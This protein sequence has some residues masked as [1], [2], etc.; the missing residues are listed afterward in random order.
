MDDCSSSRSNNNNNVVAGDS[1]PMLIGGIIEKGF[2]TASKSTSTP[3][4]RPTVLPFP[5]PRHRSHGPHWSSV[6]P[7]IEDKD[8]DEDEDETN[9]D[10]VA[11]SANP[12]QRKKKKGL[13]FGN[14]REIIPSDR[15]ATNQRNQMKERE[16]SAKE[17]ID[18]GKKDYKGINVSAT[19]L[20]NVDSFPNEK[21]NGEFDKMLNM[22]IN[23]IQGSILGRPAV[24]IS[25][26]VARESKSDHSP[27]QSCNDDEIVSQSY[28][29]NMFEGSDGV[30]LSPSLANDIDAE[31][32]ARLE[33][34]SSDEIAE[35]QAEIVGKM[36]PNILE[37]LKKRGR[38]KLANVRS[39]KSG[40]EKGNQNDV[41]HDRGNLQRGLKG[42]QPREGAEGSHKM[43]PTSEHTHSNAS[44][45]HLLPSS[46]QGS[47]FWK[48][49]AERVEAVR[50]L[51]FTLDGHV[52]ETGLTQPS[53]SGDAPCS[54][55]SDKNVAERDFL[56]TEG[57]PGGAGYTIKEAVALIRS[58]IPGQRVLALRLLAS[59]L[60]KALCNLELK[61]A[62]IHMNGTDDAIKS[63]DWQ[64]IW[65]YALGPEPEI[66]LSLRMA[67]DDNHN[68]VILSCAKVIHSI[69]SCEMNE[70]FFNT[71]EKLANYEMGLYTAPI[72]R[73]RPDIKDGFLNG[74]FWKYN[75]KPSNVLPFIEE[76][77]ND[78]A[79]G[80]HT[81]QDDIVVAGQDIA[82]GLVRMGI[83]PRIR[84][85]LE[86]EPV[87]V[88]DE[89]LISI[90]IALGRH[91][92]E[93]AGAI[94]KCT[95]LVQT[96]MQ[97]YTKRDDEA[98]H[99]SMIKSARLIRVLAQCN[100]RYCID[101]IERGFFWVIMSHLCKYAFSP[102]LD[103]WIKSGKENC[104]L[105][106][107]FIVEQLSLWKVCIQYGYCVSHFADLFPVL[108]V[109]LS[110]PSFD[111]LIKSN[112]LGEFT[113]ISR[114]AYFVLAA[115]AKQLPELHS[116]EQ[117]NN[118]KKISDNN[119][120]AWSWSHVSPMVDVAIKW[121]S[122]KSNPYLSSMFDVREE[123]ANFTQDSSVGS[124]VCIISAVVHMLSCVLDRIVPCDANGQ[125]GNKK[126]LPW[127]PDFVPKIGLTI[128]NSGLL[129]LSDT[130]GG[131]SLVECLSRLRCYNNLELSL[132]FISCLQCLV[133]LAV[134]VD[135]CIQSAKSDNCTDSQGCSFE[136]D[137]VILR[138]GIV[139]WCLNDLKILLT[140]FMKFIASGW[141][142]FRSIEIYGRGGP[143]PGSGVGWGASA[144]GFWS[145]T[146]LLIQADA[147]LVLCLQEHFPIGLDTL[148]SSLQDREPATGHSIS[149]TSFTLQ[150]INSIL[151]VCLIGGPREKIT[152]EKA[153]DILLQVPTLKYFTF[154]IQRLFRLNMKSI[155][156]DYMLISR[157]LNTHFRNR[158]LNSKK[159]SAKKNNKEI[160]D[161]EQK[162]NALDT[163]H[164][165]AEM[166]ETTSQHPQC[167]SLVVE[168]AYQRLPLPLHWFLSPISTFGDS[169]TAQ[170]VMNESNSLAKCGIFLLLGLEA[171][172]SISSDSEHSPV[173]NVPLV[174][175]LHA[176]SMVLLV[177]TEILEDETYRA[178]YE[179]LQDLYSHDLGNS[180][181]RNVQ[182][183]A[184]STADSLACMETILVPKEKSVGTLKFQALVHE[185]YSTFIDTLVEQFGAMSYGDVLFGRQVAVYLHC[186]VEEPVRLAT[187]NALSNAHVLELLPPLDK[188]LGG[189]EGYLE[190]VE[191]N[192][193]ILEAY[194][195]S[196]MSGGLDKAAARTSISFTLALHHLSSFIFHDRSA[197]KLSLR[198]KLVKSILRDYARKRHH[199]DLTLQF[200]RYKLPETEGALAKEMCRRFELLSEACEGN[201]SLLSEVMR[202]KSCG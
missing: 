171:S 183:S 96:I 121:L 145:R 154:W 3:L 24:V 20:K 83:I 35:A 127:L 31:N 14:W 2:S 46:M 34:M 137:G 169:D 9:L 192:E 155:E 162:R 201:S 133:Q 103:Q 17:L 39:S 113:S 186:L 33:Q 37:M 193:R 138:E 100:K 146:V 25:D 105:S 184:D 56:R 75:T 140:V 76:N 95:G 86:M 79:E 8:G 172:S 93:S 60:D 78:E 110:P 125:Q 139:K 91:S 13:N 98:I 73:S 164:E 185:S 174:W 54:Q 26:S 84:Y 63:V 195:K 198:N 124:L 189:A 102:G 52:L 147:K 128:V 196:W 94:I 151:H 6:A 131:V 104:Q 190:P 143:A 122:L 97:R 188:C 21:S 68:S 167:D 123:S 148:I 175:K 15:P 200:V 61:D 197:E 11:C 72:F 170:D 168:W 28:D 187:W 99:P 176:L 126:P 161:T 49:W 66:A 194:M 199:E 182:P 132:S 116:S 149:D 202:L 90:L 18:E 109:W 85:L 74:G 65:A 71:S 107:A 69:L 77:V 27:G 129:K 50:G 120:E 179:T 58:I 81:I 57:D 158:W 119:M 51:R 32:R 152:V 42:R 23:E 55:Y 112:L 40:L 67:L 165:D 135:K 45:G 160:A 150:R 136:N 70:N 191:E 118:I 87:P 64:A 10:H 173:S 38:E 159:K 12:V 43:T 141:H 142:D 36:N 89:Y 115:L 44:M 157:T 130:N 92:P 30:S 22:D 80:K 177:K 19:A 180:R 53:T 59:I 156:E 181:Q 144:G 111:K 47:G 88:L 106:S 7:E 108:C 48:S 5:V 153:F 41:I 134:S 62:V 1:S 101:F 117:T 16:F 114:E 4:P 29:Y 82:A 178:V 166:S 163:I